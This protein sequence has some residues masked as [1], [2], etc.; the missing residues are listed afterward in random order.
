V[1]TDDQLKE[2]L[3][4]SNNTKIMN[5]VSS[6]YINAIGYDDLESEK[7]IVLWE[8]LETYDPD[9][10]KKFTS[11][12]YQKLDWRYKKI[13]REQRRQKCLFYD[14]FDAKIKDNAQNVENSIGVY[15]DGLPSHLTKVV[16]QYYLH[17][18]TIEEIGNKNHYSRETARRL[19]KK[20]IGKI[21]SK[22]RDN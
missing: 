4:D 21:R 3:S 16:I 10:K 6:K 7:L 17:N 19:I 11:F 18:M 1:V 14:N 15:T 12:L 9:R 8:C 2:A 22:W 20:A 5:K 13:L